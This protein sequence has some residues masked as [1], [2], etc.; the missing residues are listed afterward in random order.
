[1]KGDGTRIIGV[2]IAFPTIMK[3]ILTLV[4][5]EVFFLR[6][7][8]DGRLT[9]ISCTPFGFSENRISSKAVQHDTRVRDS[10]KVR[11]RRSVKG[12]CRER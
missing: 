3:P 1:M 2:Y 9:D 10:K 6:R 7:Y 11:Q 4:H 5:S 12:A 8:T